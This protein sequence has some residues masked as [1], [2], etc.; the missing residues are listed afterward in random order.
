MVKVY[1]EDAE[2]NETQPMTEEHEIKGTAEKVIVFVNDDEMEAYQHET[3]L[4]I[5]RRNAAHIGFACGGFGICMACVVRV[6]QGAEH[7]TA[8]NGVERRGLGLWARRDYRLACQ[9][10]VTG[11][12]PVDIISRPEE[13][14]RQTK[15]LLNTPSN[16][17]VGKQ[18]LELGKMVADMSLQQWSVFPMNSINAVIQTMRARPGPGDASRLV[19]DT[20]RVIR[21]VREEDKKEA[22]ERENIRREQ[23][24]T[25]RAEQAEQNVQDEQDGHGKQNG[26]D[27][28]QNGGRDAQPQQPAQAQQP[29]QPSQP[30]TSDADNEW[31]QPPTSDA[32]NEW[33]QPSANTQQSTEGT[34]QS[35]ESR[36][37]HSGK[38][39]RRRGE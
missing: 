26:Q 17:D 11:P 38:G 14:W 28:Q 10:H 18:W 39:K 1:V 13:L 29:Q 7:L 5:A 30:P 31:Q 9:A 4:D 8:P 32:D 16:E 36:H 6:R 27:K 20:L 2:Y 3:L 35:S 21:R 19:N 23:E 25:E 34:K 12:G 37:H 33:Q 22:E 15:A 24:E